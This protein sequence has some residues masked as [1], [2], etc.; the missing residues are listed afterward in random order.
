MNKPRKT[1]SIF[2]GFYTELQNIRFFFLFIL[3]FHRVCCIYWRAPI[4]RK[5]Y[6]VDMC[7]GGCRSGYLICDKMINTITR[8][9]TVVS[10]RQRT[11]ELLHT[12]VL[13][14]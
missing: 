5:S 11:E 6:K 4:L 14:P 10:Q 2:N 7:L 12:V 8:E 9:N 13:L 1:Y 3:E